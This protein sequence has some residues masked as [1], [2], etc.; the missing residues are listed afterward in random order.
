MVIATFNQRI[1]SR[2]SCSLY[3]RYSSLSV[4]RLWWQTDPYL[5]HKPYGIKLSSDVI[6]RSYLLSWRMKNLRCWHA[7]PQEVLR[8]SVPCIPWQATTLWYA[9]YHHRRRRHRKSD[10]ETRAAIL[11]RDLTSFLLIS[12]PFCR[13]N[14]SQVILEML[15]CALRW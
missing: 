3:D 10:P 12:L 9:V 14:L 2:K 8:C 15:Y 7:G 13:D 11:S 4:S 6:P 5:N 1:T